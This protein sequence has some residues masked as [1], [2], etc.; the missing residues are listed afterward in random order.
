M[1]LITVKTLRQKF[2]D[3]YLSVTGSNLPL[4]LRSNDKK[5]LIRKFEAQTGLKYTN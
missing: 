1:E 4:Y 5:E 2:A 3:W